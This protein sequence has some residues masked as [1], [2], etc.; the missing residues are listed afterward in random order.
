M[1][2]NTNTN[3]CN[4]TTVAPAP[5]TKGSG[6]KIAAAYTDPN[7]LWVTH[8]IESQWGGW[9]MVAYST[10]PNGNSI[11]VTVRVYENGSFLFASILDAEAGHKREVTFETVSDVIYAANRPTQYRA[12]ADR[13]AAEAARQQ[14]RDER[15][16]VAEAEYAA[17]K[18]TEADNYKWERRTLTRLAEQELSFTLSERYGASNMASEAAIFVQ[19]QYEMLYAKR[20]LAIEGKYNE[21]TDRCYTL[22]EAINR[23]VMAAI[24]NSDATRPETAVAHAK[25]LEQLARYSF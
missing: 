10:G 20:A 19:K 5:F 9:N 1:D 23:T 22:T 12:E 2:N 14:A 15:A 16:A 4:I 25:A 18:D 8:F 7:G 24:C 11:N 13:K 6:K 17:I 21:A 3:N